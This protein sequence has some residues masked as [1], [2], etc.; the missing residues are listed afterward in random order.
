M[1]RMLYGFFDELAAG[2]PDLVSVII[3]GNHDSAGRIEAPAP[4]LARANVVAIGSLHM[5]DGVPKLDDHLVPVPR[6]DKVAGYILAIPYLRPADLP[7]PTGKKT[8]EGKSSL[9]EGIRELYTKAVSQAREKI[10]DLPLVVTGHLHVR[11]AELS[12]SLSERRIVLGGEHAVP[13]GVFGDRA[14]YVALGHLH[15]AQQFPPKVSGCNKKNAKRKKHKA[16]LATGCVRYAGSPMP[17][18]V[19]ER[20]YDHGVSLVEINKKNHVSVHHISLERPVPFLRVPEKGHL[21]IEEIEAALAALDLD[22]KAEQERWPFVQVALKI[23]GPQ[24]G[25]RAR[26]DEI[27][28]AFPVRDVA[29]D[30]LWPGQERAGKKA[31]A[32]KRLDE[33]RPAD[34]FQ[35][36]FFEHYGVEPDEQQIACF[37][38]LVEEAGT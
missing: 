12:E 21:G 15:R 33:H 1:Y 29:P 31:V 8:E 36:A 23:S 10:G 6:G 37:H 4:L 20:Q 7:D 26:L 14:D 28:A 18:S 25:F 3:A 9:V 38:Q 34:L 16:G 2:N 19:V 11:G 35:Q 24:P 32:L 30:I 17:L 27:F 5:K 13:A 22:E